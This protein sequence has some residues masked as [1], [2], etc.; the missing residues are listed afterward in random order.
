MAHERAIRDARGD[1]PAAAVRGREPVRV[2]IRLLMRRRC[3][4]TVRRRG[5]DALG[6][7]GQSPEAQDLARPPRQ[8]DTPKLKTHDRQGRRIDM[9][10]F[11]PA[12]HALMRRSCRA[13]ACIAS[14]WEH[15]DAETRPAPPGRAPARFYMAAQMEAGHCCPITMTSA[16]LAALLSSPSCCASG[17]R[18]S[19]SRNY[20]QSFSAAGRED[21]P[22][23][24]HGHDGEAGRH[25]RARQRRPRPSRSA[26]GR[27]ISPHRPQMV[28]VGAD[29][30]RLPGAG[31][32]AGRAHLL[33]RAA[34]PAATAA[35]TR[36]ASSG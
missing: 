24:R 10:E 34:L 13:R 35:S 8:R 27:R 15:G 17:R 23:A 12:Y 31:A 1:E 5:F 28:H 18:A 3:S 20:D 26:G 7:F 6:R 14:I 25:R 29:V 33:S 9:V 16:S 36:C 22:D 32:G 19:L 21:R 4:A 30:G 2:A 11:H